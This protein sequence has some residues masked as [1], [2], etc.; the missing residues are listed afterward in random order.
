MTITA[1]TLDGARTTVNHADIETLRRAVRGEVIVAG[2]AGYEEAR[3]VWNGNVD[4]RPAVIVRC[5][6]AA[7]VQQAVNVRDRSASC[8]RSAGAATARPDT[9]R[10]T[11]ASSSICRA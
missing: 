5:L 7:D 3:R 4:R 10:M 9:A 2:Q 11:A 1:T 8:C 6:D